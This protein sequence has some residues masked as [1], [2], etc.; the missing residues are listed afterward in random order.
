MSQREQHEDDSLEQAK[1]SDILG[2]QDIS[3]WPVNS[4]VL[5]SGQMGRFPHN[6]EFLTDSAGQVGSIHLTRG[7]FLPK[8][9]RINL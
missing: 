7:Q 6:L 4:P 2:S 9:H 5:N 1:D 3:D 8:H